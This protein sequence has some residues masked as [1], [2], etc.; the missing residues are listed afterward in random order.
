[1]EP[2][3]LLGQLAVERLALGVLGPQAEEPEARDGRNGGEDEQDRAVTGGHGVVPP[4]VVEAPAV[5]PADVEV[6]AVVAPVAPVLVAP[7]AAAPE[8]AAS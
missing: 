2:G 6:A 1:M 7:A 8:A 4:V 5:D 3:L